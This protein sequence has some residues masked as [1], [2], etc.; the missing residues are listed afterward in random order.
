MKSSTWKTWLGL[1]SS[2]AA[3]LA[4]VLLVT[5]G[6]ELWSPLIP[7]F[8][9]S[10]RSHDGDLNARLLLTVG[11]YGFFRDALEAANYFAGG[12]IAGRF[13]TRRSLLLFNALP[14]FGLGLLVIWPSVVSVFLAIP[15]IFLWDSIAGPAILTVVSESVPSDRRT[16]VFS[17]QAIVRRLSRMLAYAI[18]AGVVLWL[19]TVN[20]VRA[21]AGI[22]IGFVLLALWIQSRHMKTATRDRSMAIQQ[23]LK[24]LRSFPPELKRLL[25]SDILARW[26][27]GLAGP[28]VILFCV[29]LLSSNSVKGTATYQSGLLTIQAVT[30]I[31]LYI[32]V[33]PMASREGLAKRPFVG[34]TFLFFA[35]FPVSLAVLGTTFGYLGLAIAFVVGG[36]REIGE[37]AR[38]A[39]ITD[40]VPAEVKTQAIG[41][42]WS[43]RSAAVMWASPVGAAVWIL[44]DAVWVGTGGVITFLFAGA[45]GLIGAG[46]YM[47][48]SSG[49]RWSSA[50]G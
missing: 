2:T 18:S 34:L 1:N 17:I 24:L 40:L 29:P 14:L 31:V 9:K 37:P 10:L 12:A 20:G 50:K 28:F 26:A 6:T 42:Y 15:F 33:G 43:T 46:L 21:D 11:F 41:L 45:I 13:N 22:A 48:G 30:S 3:L 35:L 8:L 36:L 5:A 38:K 27:E 39:L 4:T 19:G 44:G 16:M 32:L 25:A 49:N 23:P 7:Q 47:F